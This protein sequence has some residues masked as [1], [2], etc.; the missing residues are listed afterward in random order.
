MCSFPLT[1]LALFNVSTARSHKSQHNCDMEIPFVNRFKS[2]VKTL[3]THTHTQPY[4]PT[5]TCMRVKLCTQRL[6]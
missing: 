2:K 4:S 3:N 6:V 1:I 5:Y